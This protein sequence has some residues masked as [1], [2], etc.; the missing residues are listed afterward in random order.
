MRKLILKNTFLLND[1]CGFYF[2]IKSD[3]YTCL[4]G[5]IST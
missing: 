1:P 3:Y 5:I 4:N 2:K